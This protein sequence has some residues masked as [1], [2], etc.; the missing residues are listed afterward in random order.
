MIRSSLHRQF[1]VEAHSS[2]KIDTEIS[3]IKFTDLFSG[4]VEW[5]RISGANCVINDL[6]FRRF[7]LNCEGFTFSLS[8][9]IK[10]R[11]LRLISIRPTKVRL[12]I[13]ERDLTEYM[14][15]KYLDLHPVFK[16]T[17]NGVEINA[18]ATVYGNKIPITVIGQLLPSGS[19]KIQFQPESLRISGRQLPQNLIQFISKQIPLE[20]PVL[21]NWPL[22]ID[23]LVTQKNLLQLSLHEEKMVEN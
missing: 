11:R 23:S 3:W 14:T 22:Q 2:G 16:L 5:V 10:E 20:F 8:E 13:H 18:L 7:F 4:K 21:E 17:K 19:K 15:V 12:T 6:R 1:I 9:L